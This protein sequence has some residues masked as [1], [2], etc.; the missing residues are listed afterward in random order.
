MTVVQKMN[1]SMP[2][3]AFIIL[4]S[5]CSFFS[6]DS[7]LSIFKFPVQPGLDEVVVY[8]A[9]EPA[10]V[11]AWEYFSI[12]VGDQY[13]ILNSGDCN[14][15][16][17]KEKKFTMRSKRNIEE[18]PIAELKRQDL[19]FGQ[20]YYFLQVGTGKDV[21]HHF[22]EVTAD[23]IAPICKKYGFGRV[24]NNPPNARWGKNDLKNE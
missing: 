9:S 24:M 15:F 16:L 4:F 1:K 8:V 23:D 12:A 7:S 11:S 2:T 10:Y 22:K 21:D 18:Y 6:K 5:G 3:I 19:T 17:I 20:S 14:Y 13:K